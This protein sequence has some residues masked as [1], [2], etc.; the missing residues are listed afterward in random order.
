MGR[1]KKGAPPALK[2]RKDGEAYV[3]V[4]DHDPQQI[5]MGRGDEITRRYRQFLGDWE[6]GRYRGDQPK[7]SEGCTVA[8][9]Y[10]AFAAHADARYRRDDGTPTGEAKAFDRSIKPLLA[11][12]A[13][14]LADDVTAREL[15]TTRQDMVD[16]GLS[17]RVV[18]QRVGRIR[19]VWRWGVA[20]RIV[21]AATV[22]ELESLPDLE[23]GYSGM[24]DPAPV[25]AVPLATVEA[26]LPRLN[27]WHQAMV[28]L[29]LL[30]GARPGEVCG[31]VGA[32]IDQDGVVRLKDH[33]VRLPGVWVWQPRWHKSKRRGK[34][35]VYIL[36]PKAIELLRP[37]LRDDPSEPLF[38]P[39]E[40]MAEYNA[41]RIARAKFHNKSPR[42]TNPR[43]KPGTKYTTASYDLAITKAA[44]AA[45]SPHWS[46][47]QLRKLVASQTDQA[48]GI[49]SS[50]KRLGHASIATTEIY[51]EAD[52]K[53]AA[54]LAKLYG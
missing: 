45:G 53:E 46:A 12:C 17:R 38:Q 41:A 4:H 16:A 54:R 49:E 43:R 40:A 32:D 47:H 19:R 35:L 24:H 15:K 26:T 50:R 1:R 52:L 14:M 27:R 7:A 22:V 6:R 13:T 21:A 48:E 28:R 44:A 37:W 10:C 51:V 8:E 18:N 2:Y 30:T 3:Y 29:Q 23:A 34:L 31:I 9:L 33:E 25:R 5:S 11:R 20:E 42:A 39:R 36:G